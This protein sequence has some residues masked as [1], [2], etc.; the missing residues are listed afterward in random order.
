MDTQTSGRENIMGIQC[1]SKW[2]GD[3][4]WSTRG[5]SDR[6]D[7][8]S[9]QLE[10]YS[11]RFIQMYHRVIEESKLNSHPNVLRVIQVSKGLLPV[12]IM[13]P[14]MPD[15][16]ITHYTQMNPDADRLVLVC[17]CRWRLIGIIH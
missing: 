10:A 5:G 9:I 2:F 1:V 11:V 16:N 6:Y 4:R 15:G 7:N 8:R 17:A 12:C 14:W 3:R 13:S